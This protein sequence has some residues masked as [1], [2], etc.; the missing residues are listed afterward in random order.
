MSMQHATDLPPI[1]PQRPRRRYPRRRMHAPWDSQSTKIKNGSALIAG[2]NQGGFYIRRLRELIADYNGD[3]PEATAAERSLIKRAC[4]LEIELERLETG[5]AGSDKASQRGLDLYAR[6]VGNLRR[7]LL[8][9]GLGSKRQRERNNAPGPLG[10]LL[11]ADIERQREED[12]ERREEK[13]R[14]E[15]AI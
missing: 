2:V 11:I 3:L 9:L 4:I 7:V 13:L 1:A 12:R 10:R 5:L 15:E 6:T 8:T 14:E